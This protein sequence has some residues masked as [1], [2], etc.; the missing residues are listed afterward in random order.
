MPDP[1]GTLADARGEDQGWNGNWTYEARIDGSTWSAEGRMAFADL[2]LP[3]PATGET[4][5]VE[6]MDSAVGWSEPLTYE[7][8]EEGSYYATLSVAS[9]QYLL[10]KYPREVRTTLE[11]TI[12]HP[13]Q[14][15]RFTD[16]REALAQAIERLQAAQKR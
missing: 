9:E 2:G 14:P 10:V 13:D 16:A 1:R 8:P 4:W 6:A 15:E 7:L 12:R 5:Q 3:A 11:D